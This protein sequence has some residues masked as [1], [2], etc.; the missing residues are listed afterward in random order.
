M[1]EVKDIL[2]MREQQVAQL[3]ARVDDLEDQLAD[4]KESMSRGLGLV[5]P[6][7]RPLL[8]NTSTNTTAAASGNPTAAA[9]GAQGKE[10]Q[11]SK[12]S[13]VGALW[14]IFKGG[15]NNKNSN[16]SS[17]E[18]QQP[19]LPRGPLTAEQLQAA[20]GASVEE[21]APAL[22]EVAMRD[23]EGV[24]VQLASP[25]GM[26]VGRAA[27]GASPAP[28]G[29]VTAA[30]EGARVEEAVRAEPGSAAMFTWLSAVAGQ[31]TEAP[32][33]GRSVGGEAPSGGKSAGGGG[34]GS[35]VGEAASR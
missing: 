33:Q 20:A 8:T 34:A 18:P 16:K 1:Q 28:G 35:G 19:S 22:E 3:Q 32:G 10:Q 17:P 7:P 29:G 5:L 26:G 23:A 25:Q 21:A 30:E 4:I 14:S 6:P 24:R 13:F 11:E 27:R 2:A 31:D 9:A 15:D 12:Q